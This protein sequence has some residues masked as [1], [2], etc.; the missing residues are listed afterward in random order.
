MSRSTEKVVFALTFQLRLCQNPFITTITILTP[1]LNLPIPCN[2]LP[3]VRLQTPLKQL[4]QHL[5]TYPTD[6]GVVA[7]F[8][9]LVSYESVCYFLCISP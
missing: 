8:A 4:Q 5:E 9:E 2:P 1:S 6:G 3:Q 7:A